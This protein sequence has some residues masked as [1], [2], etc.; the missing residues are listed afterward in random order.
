MFAAAHRPQDA[1]LPGVRR[2]DLA[3]AVSCVNRPCSV[4]PLSYG[5][6]VPKEVVVALIAVGGVILTQ[7]VTYTISRQGAR[8]LRLNISREID[9]IKKLRADSTEAKLLEAHVKTSIEKLI[10][11]DERRELILQTLMTAAPAPVIVVAVYGLGAWKAHGVPEALNPLVTFVYWFLIGGLAYL[12]VRT[13]WGAARIIWTLVR[14][15]ASITW[16]KFTMRR[17]LRKLRR[18]LADTSS[19][20]K[21][22][23]AKVSAHEGEIIEAVGQDDWNAIAEVANNFEKD[24]VETEKEIEDIERDIKAVKPARQMLKTFWEIRTGRYQDPNDSSPSAAQR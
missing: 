10:T 15:W 23:M 17:R 4:A 8:D 11:R 18:R 24:R 12:S 16:A 19:T 3:A 9:I 2:G 7:L 22:L 1:L 6:P 13:V 5:R 21:E 14:G 20:A